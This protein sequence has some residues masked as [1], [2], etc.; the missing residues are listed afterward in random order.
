MFMYHGWDPMLFR[1]RNNFGAVIPTSG[2]LKPT[3]LVGGYGHLTFQAPDYVPNQT[4]HDL[5]VNFEKYTPPPG[6]PR[7]ATAAAAAPGAA[8][9]TTA[10]T[11]ASAAP[12]APTTHQA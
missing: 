3:S 1:G 8:A 5:T 2:L 9:R 11:L 10:S 6:D 7:A 4:Y 12:L